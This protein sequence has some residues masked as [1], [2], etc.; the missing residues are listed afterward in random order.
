MVYVVRMLANFLFFQLDLPFSIPFYRWLLCEENTLSL[1][2]LAWVAPEV[3]AT[4]VR[5]LEV[6]RQRDSIQNDP[7][8]DVME[9][10]EKVKAIQTKII[11]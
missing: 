3:Q 9:K 1:A 11:S 7:G 10:T 8:L 5:L 4:L 2:D 6:V